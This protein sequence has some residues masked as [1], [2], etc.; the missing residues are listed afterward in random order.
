MGDMEIFSNG[1]GVGVGVVG[2]GVGVGL[3]LGVRV[4]VGVGVG[5]GVRR[6]LLMV[7]VHQVVVLGIL[8]YLVYLLK[9]I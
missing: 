8:I 2:V 6:D 3:G 9:P 7:R 5:V 1:F 4:G